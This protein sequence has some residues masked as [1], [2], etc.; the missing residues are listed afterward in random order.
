MPF[1]SKVQD[2]EFLHN[3]GFAVSD[4]KNNHREYEHIK[5]ILVDTRWLMETC[6]LKSQ[7]S[8]EM[9]AKKIRE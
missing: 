4:W 3:I 2:K 5:G 9:L 8:N 1:D 6:Y 7:E